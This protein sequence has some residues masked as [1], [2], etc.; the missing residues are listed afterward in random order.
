[1]TAACCE[2]WGRLFQNDADAVS[3]AASLLDI[4]EFRLFEMAHV[5]WFGSKP[6]KKT[7]EGFFHSYLQDGL[8][9]FW[10]RH[11]V[12][13]IINRHSKGHLATREFGIEEP[14]PSP[15]GKKRGWIVMGLLS[16][17]VFA[18]VWISKTLGPKWWQ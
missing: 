6:P 10:L 17:L 15:L 16:V 13:T 9:P 14:H 2:Y 12:R 18:M 8:V 7:M 5:N 3:F 4:S 1:M 11:M